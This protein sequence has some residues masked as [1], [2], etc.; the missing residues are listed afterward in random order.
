[1]VVPV[2]AGT[3]DGWLAGGEGNVSPAVAQV[4]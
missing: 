1:M 3:P 2:P 4:G